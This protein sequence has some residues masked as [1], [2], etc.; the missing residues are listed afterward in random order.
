MS[1]E[2]EGAAL[3]RGNGR[4]TLTRGRGSCCV[5]LAGIGELFELPSTNSSCAT[6]NERLA[7]RE[8][9]RLVSGVGSGSGTP[10]GL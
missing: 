6:M 9:R 8:V 3:R 10:A 7:E 1:S 4:V 2:S 5:P